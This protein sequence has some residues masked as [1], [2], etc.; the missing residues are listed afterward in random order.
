MTENL[1]KLLEK[2]KTSLIQKRE[3][4]ENNYDESSL[5]NRNRKKAKVNEIL[6]PANVQQITKNKRT[7]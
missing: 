6:S 3:K 4:E 1:M 7:K 5:I 2:Y